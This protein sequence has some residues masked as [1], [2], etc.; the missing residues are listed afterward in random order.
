M[1][2]KET[3]ILYL[4]NSINNFSCQGLWFSNQISNQTKPKAYHI[5][6][7]YQELIGYLVFFLD[8]KLYRI[9]VWIGLLLKF[10]ILFTNR[11]IL[12][13]GPDVLFSPLWRSDVSVVLFVLKTYTLIFCHFKFKQYI[14]NRYILLV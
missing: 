4:S 11:F 2:M 7:M 6:S 5:H 12:H 3:V 10:P 1:H 9:N 14:A 13:V 8:Q